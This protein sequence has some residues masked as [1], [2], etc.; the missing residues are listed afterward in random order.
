M[1]GYAPA[2]TFVI[3]APEDV[4]VTKTLAGLIPQFAIP[5]RTA[6]TSPS[7]SEPPLCVSVAFVF[8][9]QQPPERG[10]LP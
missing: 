2:I 5:Y 10:E 8:T 6:F 3:I 4:P 1:S 9:S 7:E